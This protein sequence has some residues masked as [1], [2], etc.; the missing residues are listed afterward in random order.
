VSP[1]R[2]RR[3]I[4]CIVLGLKLFRVIAVAYT[5]RHTTAL[6]AEVAELTQWLDDERRWRDYAQGGGEGGGAYDQSGYD[7]SAQ[8]YDQSGYD[9]SGYDQSQAYQSQAHQ[10]P[11]Y[12]QSAQG[13]DQSA[14]GYDQSAQGYDQSAQG[15]DQSA[16]GYD[17]S[18]AYDQSQAGDGRAV[19]QL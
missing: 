19:S 15:Y 2:A 7:Q 16:Q 13:Y 18:T 10:S 14:Q 1:A 11:G 9:V 8:G 12:D 17:Q 6:R 5:Y 3:S 4:S